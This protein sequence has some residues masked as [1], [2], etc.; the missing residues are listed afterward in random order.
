M[1]PKSRALQV[2]LRTNPDS[3]ER[4]NPRFAICPLNNDSAFQGGH[5]GKLRISMTHVY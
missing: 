5:G 4:P 1:P 3:Q 2:V